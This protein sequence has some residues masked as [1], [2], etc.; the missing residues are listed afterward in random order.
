[1]FTGH[2]GGDPGDPTDPATGPEALLPAHNQSQLDQYSLAYPLQLT[3]GHAPSL[4]GGVTMADKHSSLTQPATGT[5]SGQT[6][7]VLVQVQQVSA[8]HTANTE[9]WEEA[10]RYDMI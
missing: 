2:P 1:M 5:S 9:R 6:A 7:E 4:L 3:G 8:V 10:I